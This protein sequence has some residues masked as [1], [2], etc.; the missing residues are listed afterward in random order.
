MSTT[1]IPE[2]TGQTASADRSD[3]SCLV[4]RTGPT[5]QTGH[6]D[7]SDRSNTEWLQQRLDQYRA[8]TND[9][10]EAIEDSGDLDKLGQGFASADPLEKVDIGDGTIPRPTFVN[11][12]LSVEYKADLVNLLKEYVDCFAWEYHEMPG[13][14]RDLVEHSLP[15]KAGF[16]PYKKPVKHFNPI[17]YDRIKTEINHL[18]DAGFIRSCRYTDWISNIV[19]VE[20]KNSGKIRVC[21]DF[22]DLNTSTPKD[23]YPMPIADMLINEASGYRVISFL[24]GNAGYNQIFM[25]EEDISKTVFRCPGFVGLFEWVVMTF[26]LKNAGATYQRAMNLIFHNLVGV[27]LEVYIDDIVIKSAGLGN[28]LANLRLALERM[29]RYGLKMNPLKCAFGVSAGKFLGFIIHE[30]GIEIDPKRVEAMKKVEAPT[31]KKDLQK[32]L[33]KVNFLRKFISNLSG[34]IDAF[35]PILRL[36][37]ETEFTWGAK[38]QEAFEKI[39]I[40]LSSPLVLKAPRRGVPFRLYVATEDK[41]IGAILAQETEGKEYIITYLS[42]RLIDAET[43]YTFIKK[44][45]LS[46]Y[47]ACTKLRHYL[48][49]STCIVVYQT[50][51]IKHMLQKPI[52]S[53]RIGKWAYAFVEYDLA[54]EPLKSMR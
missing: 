35:T 8:R 7:R 51:V 17:I 30:K 26:G 46:L 34:K 39:K 47:Y 23:E 21:I 2:E 43:R 5:G 27:I 33:G 18:L 25:A 54:C 42:R 6:P 19:P 11:K 15:I 14:S 10:C 45:C 41:V 53:G 22:G 3:R 1:E 16:R 38:Q 37:D 20:K 24:D 40:Y 13:L 32:F 36:K 12:N 31:C 50:D 29:R 48:L 49:S 44:L 9:I 4:Q 52:L 28:H